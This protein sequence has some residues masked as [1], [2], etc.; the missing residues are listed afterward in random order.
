MEQPPGVFVSVDGPCGVG[1]STT[2]RALGERLRAV[3]VPR[4]LTAEPTG[5]E[6]GALACARVHSDTCGHALACLF[7]AD[8]YHHLETEIRP[9]LAAGD[10]VISDRYILAGLVMQRFDGVDLGFLQA[11]NA[12]ADPPDLAVILTADP[13][14]IA[15]R[16]QQ[17]RLR[18]RYQHQPDVSA[19]ESTLYLDAARALTSA[20]AGAA[21]GDQLL[22][23]GHTRLDDP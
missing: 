10:I 19:H 21:A 18:N 3:G 7:A 17:R 9:R 20:G 12:L 16:L 2:I 1:K 5:S 23:A 11:I 22:P 13:A 6:I 14:L 8:R 15:Q 4:H